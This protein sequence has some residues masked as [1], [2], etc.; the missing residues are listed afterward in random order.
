MS[1]RH[2]SIS[3]FDIVADRPRP[4]DVRGVSRRRALGVFGREIR[5]RV[6]CENKRL[7]YV[8]AVR[9]H[10]GGEGEPVLNLRLAG[11]VYMHTAT[12][13]GESLEKNT[14]SHAAK[15]LNSYVRRRCESAIFVYR[16]GGC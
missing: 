12:R 3:V 14:G 2:R 11:G 10:G 6:C 7:L 8:R 15:T 5:G 4:R 9:Q 16:T 13:V 1:S